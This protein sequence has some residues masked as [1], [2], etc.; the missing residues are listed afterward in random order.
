ME[1]NNKQNAKLISI[2]IILRFPIFLIIACF[3]IMVAT[4]IEFIFKLFSIFVFVICNIMKF[5][6]ALTF[7]DDKLYREGMDDW[8]EGYPNIFP[9]DS[10][11]FKE[12]INFLKFGKFTIR[13]FKIL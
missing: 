4:P 8:K 12:V 10:F 6:Y 3:K 1:E 13:I 11:N 9:L 5:K 2:G 7:Q